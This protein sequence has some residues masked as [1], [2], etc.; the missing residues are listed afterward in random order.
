MGF[1]TTEDQAQSRRHGN[2]DTVRSG[3]RALPQ[4][5]GRK[6]GVDRGIFRH[7]IPA[8]ERVAPVSQ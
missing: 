7:A 8:T 3:R 4:T 1:E 6:P 5:G 2:P